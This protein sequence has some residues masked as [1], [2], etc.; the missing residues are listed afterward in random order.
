MNKKK[1]VFATE[2]SLSLGLKN[3][4]IKSILVVE[5]FSP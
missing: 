2:N 1:R 4:F 5:I 3:Y